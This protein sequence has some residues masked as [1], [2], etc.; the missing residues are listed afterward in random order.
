MTRC[1]VTFF[2]DV[3]ELEGWNPVEYL[4]AGKVTKMIPRSLKQSIGLVSAGRTIFFKNCFVAESHAMS[5]WFPRK[6]SICRSCARESDMILIKS[7]TS[8]R[9]ASFQLYLLL[10]VFDYQNQDQHCR[11]KQNSGVSS[12]CI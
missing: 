3:E 5:L 10:H 2:A 9:T 4:E 1:Q 7:L 6:G 11:S 12:S 8:L